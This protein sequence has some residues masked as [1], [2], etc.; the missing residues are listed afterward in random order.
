MDALDIDWDVTRPTAVKARQALLNDSQPEGVTGDTA[1]SGLR[2]LDERD[3]ATFAGRAMTVLMA[4][5][6]DDAGE[7]SLRAQA[8][9]RDSGWFVRCHGKPMW[10]V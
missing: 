5:P 8:L 2:P 7:L 4:A 10:R 6:V 9:L 3:L 1:S